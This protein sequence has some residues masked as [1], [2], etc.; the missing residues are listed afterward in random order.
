M[1]KE[2]S[3]QDKARLVGW[4]TVLEVALTGFGHEQ[5]YLGLAT[6]TVTKQMDSIHNTLMWMLSEFGLEG[7]A[8][9]L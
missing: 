1:A 8:K 7:V 2:L 3:E 6:P 9:G 4:L 5:I